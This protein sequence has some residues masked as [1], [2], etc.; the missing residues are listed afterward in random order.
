MLSQAH[1]GMIAALLC[2]AAW[3]AWMDATS[4]QR[5]TPY[6]API[7]A[8]KGSNKNASKV[9]PEERLA[10]YTGWLA[11]LTGFLVLASIIQGVFLLRADKTAR[12]NAENAKDTVTAT[13]EANNLTRDIFIAE[14][15]PWLLWRITS[16]TVVTPAGRHLRID[17]FGE[18]ENIGRTPALNVAYFG[19]LYRPADG[20][21]AVNRGVAYYAEHMGEIARNPLTILAHVLPT[22]SAPIRFS[23]VVET[24]DL[25]TDRRFQ[26]WLAFH[27][28]YQGR[29]GRAAEIG[30]V[31]MLQHIPIA[32]GAL[33]SPTFE[34]GDFSN[35]AVSVSLIEWQ[36]A[37]RIV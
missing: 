3:L 26:L 13:R 30:S 25:P 1:R 32:L 21:G 8:D 22:E 36:G 23:C 4:F 5:Q 27:A 7:S 14:Q 17:V 18:I 34:I 16:P 11:A 28:G 15:R 2:L 29:L 31:Y 12:I 6:Q 24:E 20:T 35:G 9:T 37:R 10:E 33:P 19:K